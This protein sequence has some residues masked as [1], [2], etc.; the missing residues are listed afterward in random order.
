MQYC[1]SKF[2]TVL[3]NLVQT[4]VLIQQIWYFTNIDTVNWYSESISILYYLE[5]C[6]SLLI[7]YSLE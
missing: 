6:T 1:T 3:E 5:Y 4:T 7:L 2:G